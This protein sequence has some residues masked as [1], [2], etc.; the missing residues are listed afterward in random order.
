MNIS[1]IWPTSCDCGGG[2]LSASNLAYSLCYCCWSSISYF[3]FSFFILSISLKLSFMLPVNERRS[4]NALGSDLFWAP[5]SFC[6][7]PLN[8]VGASPILKVFAL[9]TSLMLALG[10]GF[11]WSLKGFWPTGFGIPKLLEFWPES[12]FTIYYLFYSAPPPNGLPCDIL[13]WTLF[14][15]ANSLAILF[16]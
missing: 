2:C 10:D 15:S 9:Y 3:S 16:C 12:W 13:P 6:R 14:C 4:A 1:F 8:P 11:F 5:F 7:Y